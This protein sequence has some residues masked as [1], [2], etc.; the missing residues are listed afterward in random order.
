MRMYNL[1]NLVQI[2]IKNRIN[3]TIIHNNNNNNNN[4][5]NKLTKS[6]LPVH[7]GFKCLKS[8]LKH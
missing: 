6:Y 5:N 8:I 2:D 7:F 4:S 1:F 3:N